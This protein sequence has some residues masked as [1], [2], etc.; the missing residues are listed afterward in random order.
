[1][2]EKKYEDGYEEAMKLLRPEPMRVREFLE[3]HQ[4]LMRN[5]WFRARF[6]VALWCEKLGRWWVG[7]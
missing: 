6:V 3:V 1:M 2:P 5:P 4:Q 7:R